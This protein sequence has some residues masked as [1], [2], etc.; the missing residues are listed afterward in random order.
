MSFFSIY[1][2]ELEEQARLQEEQDGLDEEYFDILP[3]RHKVHVLR[4]YWMTGQYIMHG[5][6]RGKNFFIFQYFSKLP[7]GVFSYYQNEHML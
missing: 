4:H 6:R 5:P 1:K 2:K 7:M 3:I